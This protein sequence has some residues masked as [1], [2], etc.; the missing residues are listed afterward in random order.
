LHLLV[1]A[2][3]LV[4]AGRVYDGVLVPVVHKRHLFPRIVLFVPSGRHFIGN[5]H[6]LV[7]QGEGE[8]ARRG[9]GAGRRRPPTAACASVVSRR[10]RADIRY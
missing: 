4:D 10:N 8:R 7:Q 1:I 2:R 3:A 9:E 6:L 5:Q